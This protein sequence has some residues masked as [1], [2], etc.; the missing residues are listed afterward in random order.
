MTFR[1]VP[2]NGCR[3]DMSKPRVL[4]VCLGNICRSPLA[5][6]ALRRAAAEAGF[7]VDIES[8]GTADYHVG[9]APDPRAIEEA[10]KYGIDIKEYRGRQLR[11]RDF[12]EFDYILGMDRSNMANIARID[13]GD[14]MAKVAMLLDIVP[15]QKGR[16]VAD[17]W[18]GELDGFSATWKEVDA[19]ARAL[20]E[21]LIEE[22]G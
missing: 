14:G 22:H 13:P 4:F 11:P 5:E 20:L 10:R 15:G 12:R 2:R 19:G 3:P 7:E 16:E 6:A 17:P 1:A 21:V 18:F 8:A 9:E